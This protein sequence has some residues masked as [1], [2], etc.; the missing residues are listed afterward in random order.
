MGGTTDPADE[1][2]RRGI[3]RRA[4]L[5][6]IGVDVPDAPAAITAGA[7]LV[8]EERA[9]VLRERMRELVA[10][11]EQQSPLEQGLPVGA[12]TRALGVPSADIVTALVAEP[13]RLVDGRVT[14]QEAAVLPDAVE[15][16][17]NALAD[18]LRQDPF[19]APTA[20][21]LRDLGLDG[22]AVAAAARAGR[23]LK[24]ADGIVLLPGAA[25]LAAA[26]LA[27]LP[28]PFTTSQARQ[29]LGT[30]RRVALPLLG[31]LDELGYTRRLPDDRRVLN[32]NPGSG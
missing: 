24:V 3:V 10:A 20:D 19:A 27:D 32:E 4:L 17:V 2:S 23:L 15:K 7:W 18:D 26:W 1:V 21:R 11:H 13:L 9:A 6:Q 16:A 28:Q 31:H 5:E 14:T 29:R 8:S 12:L 25:R 30:S 22:K